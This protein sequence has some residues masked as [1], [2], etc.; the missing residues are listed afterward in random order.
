MSLRV[1]STSNSVIL[2]Q[3]YH[4]APSFV[5]LRH[6][7]YYDQAASFHAGREE[8]GREK[9]VVNKRLSEHRH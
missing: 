9:H 6:P 8:H 5:C 1:M 2:F 4:A 3:F 7:E